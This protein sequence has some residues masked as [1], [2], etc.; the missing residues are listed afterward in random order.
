[1]ADTSTKIFE[2]DTGR[3]INS[4]KEYKQYIEDLKGTL[5]ALEKGTDDYNKV[6]EEL[7]NAQQKLNE[8]MDVARGKAEG[9]EGS[10]DNLVAKMRELKKQWRATA[11]EAERSD[12]G[13]KIL[14]INDQLKALDASTGNFQRNVGDYKNAFAET[15]DKMLG[16]LGKVNGTLGTLARDVKGMIPLIKNVNTTALTGLK[17]IKAAIASTGIGLLIVAVGE[18]AAH[19]ED[20]C[21]WIKN[22]VVAQDDYNKALKE[23]ESRLNAVILKNAEY[24]KDWDA[25]ERQ[26]KILFEGYTDLTFAQERY[27]NALDA[28][29]NAIEENAKATKEWENAWAEL[30]KAEE[31]AKN[32]RSDGEIWEASQRLTKAKENATQATINYGL[33]Q[34]SLQVINEGVRVSTQNLANAKKAEENATKSNTSAHNSAKSVYEGERQAIED[35][36]RRIEAYRNALGQGTTWQLE[37]D[38]ARDKALLDKALDDGVISAE[39]HTKALNGLTLMFRLERNKVLHQMSKEL[40]ED[41][42]KAYDEEISKLDKSLSNAL[43]QLKIEDRFNELAKRIDTQTF[44]EKLADSFNNIFGSQDTINAVFDERATRL[45][46]QYNLEKKNSEDKIALYKEQIEW[47][48][49]LQVEEYKSASEEGRYAF[50]FKETEEYL[51]LQKVLAEEEMNLDNLKTQNFLD[52]AD[53]EDQRDEEL[54]KAKQARWQMLQ[55]GITATANLLNQFANIQQKQIQDDVK[56]GKITEEQARKKF[57]TVKAMQYASTVINTAQAAMGAYSAMASIPYVGPA[58]GIAAAAAATLQGLAQLKQIKAQE[59]SDTSSNTPTTPNLQPIVEN[60]YTPIVTQ[61]VTGDSELTNF[62]NAVGSIQ[63][64]VKVTDIDD[65]QNTVKVRNEENSF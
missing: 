53:L 32:A 6:A 55:M 50:N 24:S 8:V 15:F 51:N 29:K 14:K 58:L 11:D 34:K 36:I 33:A 45:N 38:F 19:W 27:N 63:P 28:Q 41:T 52:N 62:R 4:L 35:L 37:D 49:E 7:R 44:G 30:N 21:K 26:Q 54:T 16:P 65:M 2:V 12:L 31:D 13:A 64:V 18:L 9:V 23:T 22:A 39:Q 47:W 48:N 10:Y 59:F 17:G 57:K 3:A 60:A 20:V 56:N 61:N 46:D 42:T 1:M 25:V 43:N 5:L 40:V